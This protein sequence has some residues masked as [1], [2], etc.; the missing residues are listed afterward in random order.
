[1]S[2]ADRIIGTALFVAAFGLGTWYVPQVIAAGGQ[3]HFYQEEFGPAV[4]VACGHGYVN[5][6]PTPDLDAFLAVQSDAINCSSSLAA[7]SRSPL[8]AMQRAYRYLIT[9]VGWTWRL[10]GRVAWSALAPLYGL[11]LASTIVLLFAIFRQ[12]MGEL[13]AGAL[14]VVLALSPLHVSYL[15]H[16]R[17]YSKA[18]FVLALVLVAARLIRGPTDLSPCGSAR[19][20]SRSPER[21]GDG[22][23]QRFARG[24]SGI[25]G[26]AAR[27]PESRPVSARLAKPGL[28]CGVSCGASASPLVR[29]GRSIEPVAETRASTWSLL[30][31]GEPFNQELGIAGNMYEWGYGYDDELAHAIISSNATRR[32]GATTFLPLYGPE[33]DRSGSD[34]LSQVVKNFPADML[35]RAYA[36]ALRVV[37]LPYNRKLLLPPEYIQIY[38]PAQVLRLRFQRALA[39]VWLLFVAAALFMLTVWNIRIGFFVTAVDVLPGGIPRVAV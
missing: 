2:R 37:E 34:Y 39:P 11:F 12:G 1:M 9:T 10:Q 4:M 23:P 28:G 29:C 38:R 18:P 14:A 16:L 17:D 15:A 32:L 19:G 35:T 5:P 22:L 3:P 6:R 21:R 27:F 7:V 8:T 26:I 24:S 33:Y 13:V 36:S 31:L 20:W 25:R 30:G